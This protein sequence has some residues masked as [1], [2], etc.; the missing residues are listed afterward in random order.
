MKSTGEK[1]LV[2]FIVLCLSATCIPAAASLFTVD[3]GARAAAL[4]GAFIAR[5]DDPS[6]LY[7]NPAGMAFT[8]GFRLKPEVILGRQSVTATA[9]DTEKDYLARGN[10]FRIFGAATWRFAKRAA[11][12]LGVFTPHGF[13][14]DWP[15]TWAGNQMNINAS[16]SHLVIRPAVA[17]EVLPGLALGAGI[18]FIFANMRWSHYFMFNIP[19]YPLE[20]DLEILSRDLLTG[21]GVGWVAGLLW[22]VTPA[23]RLG[24]RYRPRTFL[25]LKGNNVFTLPADAPMWQTLPDPLRPGGITFSEFTKVYFKEQHVTS[26]VAVPQEI[27]GGV[28]LIPKEG[29]SLYF[30]AQWTR[31]S[32]LTAWEIRSAKTG[33]EANPDWTPQYEAF[34]GM[35]VTYLV[36]GADLA[37][38]D[39]WRFGGGVEYLYKRR[40]SFRAGFAHEG[41]TTAAA[42]PNPVYPELAR[43]SLSLGFGYEG[44]FYSVYTEEPIGEFTFDI[45]LR[46]AFTAA[47]TSLIPGYGFAYDDRQWIIGA[48]FAIKL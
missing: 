38:K 13:G 45:F 39:G 15:S 47:G 30:D 21:K 48:G 5:A 20:E 41:S 34:Y 27:A 26:R 25:T 11:A 37:L 7:I 42:G 12:G 43:N 23:F 4:G 2:L 40:F 24:V 35:P 3:I 16:L 28:M 8:T 17:V 14:T 18:D 19:N 32:E 46:R 33:L 10:R 29:L 22:K 6:S 1:R 36:Q 9:P 44:S 31:W